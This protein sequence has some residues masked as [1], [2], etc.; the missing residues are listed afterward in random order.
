MGIERTELAE[1]LM[2]LLEVP[3]DGLVVLHGLAGGFLEPVGDL[4]VQLGPRPLEQPPVGGVAHEVVMES[5]G[6]LTEEPAG[7]GLD[8]LA[9]PQRCEPGLEGRT[10]TGQ[11]V[12]EG[13][14]RELS[15]DDRGVLQHGTVLRSQTLDARGQQGVNGR[16]HL[17]LRH[18][19]GGGPSAAFLPE[20][21]V[22]H[23]HADQLADEERIALARRQHPARDGGRELARTDHV[24]GV[25]GRRAGIEPA[26]RH[27]LRRESTRDGERR[28]N[29]AQLGP[30]CD[31]DEQ[32][33]PGAPL[34]EVLGQIEQEGLRPLHVVDRE[35]DGPGRREGGQ[36]PADHEER[37]FRRRRA[38]GEERTDAVGDPGRLVTRSQG[39]DGRP[40]R[41]AVRSFV[42][43][44]R[45]AQGGRERRER[46]AAGG[47]APGH[48]HARTGR[49]P[50]RHLG[51]QA[52]LAE[53]GRSE[54]HGEPRARRGDGCLVYLGEAME[55]VLSSD[56]RGGRCALRTVQ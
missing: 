8:Q 32:R 4:R 40:H 12:G 55:L 3:S 13:G 7:V 53:A 6:R 56:E 18:L 36:Q 34:D 16:R 44:Q 46:R 33:D 52:G 9:P 28:A 41:R 24:R 38:S 15:A 25:P 29:V 20:R 19:D 31:D 43:T 45:R 11:Q 50:P 27:H 49:E 35:E 26:E 22:V 21:A 14:A 17:E 30:R 48:E 10:L 42:E 5:Q 47:V 1:I 39:F 23:Q 54:D 37:L 2:G 51:E